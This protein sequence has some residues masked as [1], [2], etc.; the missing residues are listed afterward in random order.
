MSTA[1]QV[2]GALF[3]GAMV[4]ILSLCWSLQQAHHR[5]DLLEE[6]AE[7][8]ADAPHQR[9]ATGLCPT[10]WTESDA[11]PWHRCNLVDHDQAVRHLCACG[12][13][14]NLTVNGP[15]VTIAESQD[16]A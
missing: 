13:R 3:V 11:G 2:L 9:T 5:L 7:K 16:R 8:R 10:E 1:D 6:D 12:E 15:L 14:C 4:C